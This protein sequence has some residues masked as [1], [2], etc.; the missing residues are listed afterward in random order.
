MLYCGT[1]RSTP[2]KPTSPRQ[3]FVTNATL[4]P[5][6][7]CAITKLWCHHES[8]S[9]SSPSQLK[10]RETRLVNRTIAWALTEFVKESQA[11]LCLAPAGVPFQSLGTS[12]RPGGLAQGPFPFRTERALC[13][14]TALPSS[15]SKLVGLLESWASWVLCVFGATCRVLHSGHDDPNDGFRSL[16]RLEGQHQRRGCRCIQRQGK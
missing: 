1:H 3:G 4:S 14:S 16:H 7:C 11:S 15:G 13:K 5:L 2:W 12:S 8:H 9:R 10:R 6:S